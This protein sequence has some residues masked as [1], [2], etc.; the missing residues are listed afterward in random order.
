MAAAATVLGVADGGDLLGV[1]VSFYVD[2]LS[3]VMLLLAAP[4][5]DALPHER[6]QHVEIRGRIDAA[7]AQLDRP[8]DVEV[9]FRREA[10]QVETAVATYV[11]ALRAG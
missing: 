7:I 3:A 9:R 2:H 1:S 10:D 11:M 8:S 6:M 4:D 5:A